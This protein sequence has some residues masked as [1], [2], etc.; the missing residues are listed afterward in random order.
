MDLGGV[1]QMSEPTLDPEMKDR[2]LVRSLMEEAIRSSQLEGAVTTR[3]VAKEMIRTQR[4]PRDESE[5]MILNNYNTM[6]RI[7]RTEERL[8]TPELVLGIHHTITE[9]TLEDPSAA[10]RLR[11][12]DER[13][14]VEDMYGTVFHDPP[15][16]ESLPRRMEEMCHFANS[17]SPD[18]FIHPVIRSI[19]LHFWLAYDHPFVDGN[20]RVARVLF[21]WSMLRNGYWLC[22]F[23]SISQAIHK[24]QA[25]YNRAFLYTESDENDLTYFLVHQLGVI[26]KAI[27]ELHSYIHRETAR[28]Q[29]LRRRMRGLDLLN[30]R[31]IPLI[32]HALA[33]AS[34]DFT[35]QSHRVS[36]NVV[37]ETARSDLLDLECRG[38]LLSRKVRRT[39]HFRPVQ[40][41]EARLREMS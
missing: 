18:Y 19:I 16:A 30:H 10:G 27:S 24:S 25:N 6:Q 31:Q 35:I 12:Q 39:L 13:I 40:D 14:R 3:K 11:R 21:Y 5:Q 32:E 26:R 4:A 36:H 29:N 38:L 28:F 2:Y 9:K 17:E 8:L 15:D 22:E 23:I 1:I 34:A 20:G 33:H 7:S 37:Y 41:L